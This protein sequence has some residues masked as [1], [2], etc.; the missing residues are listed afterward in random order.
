MRANHQIFIGVLSLARKH[1]HDIFDRL[2]LAMD[3]H[4]PIEGH[5][6]ERD[7]CRLSILVNIGLQGL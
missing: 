4:H 5:A 7:R 3:G 6:R 2:F 1:R